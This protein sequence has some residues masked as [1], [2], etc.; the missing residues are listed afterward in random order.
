MAEMTVPSTTEAYGIAWRELKRCFLELFLLGVV[1]AVLSAPS[2]WFQESV[3]GLAYHVLVLGPVSFGGMYAFLRAARGETPEVGDLF[4]AFQRNY[5]QAVLASLMVSALVGV[6]MVLLVV[7]GVIALVK[8]AWVPYLVIDERLDALAAVR[9]SWERT[10][11]HAM[12]IFGI[13]LLAIPLMLVGLLL[14]VVG[15]IPALV[16]VQLAS[17]VVFAAVSTRQRLAREAGVAPVGS[18]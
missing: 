9:E 15:I 4:V 1:W 5:W 12:T 11:G 13:F 7:P 2:G 10:R 16:W 8:L 17:A 6:G 3:L 18:V 14:L